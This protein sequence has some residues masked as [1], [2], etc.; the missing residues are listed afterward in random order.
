LD[1]GLWGCVFS[2]EVSRS[3]FGV[4]KHIW[5]N[6]IEK[7]ECWLASWKML[8]LFKGGRI[9]FI[10]STLFNLPADFVA[11]FPLHS[12]VANHIENLQHD[13]L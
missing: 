8:Y 10:K 9:T 2:L 4:S 1:F 3:S 5:D 11:L 12:S 7:I 13:L 6:V